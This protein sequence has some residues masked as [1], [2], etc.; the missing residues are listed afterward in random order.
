MVAFLPTPLLGEEPFN[1]ESTP[2]KLPK[3]VV[4]EEYAIRITPDVKKLTFTGSET[5]RVNVRKPTR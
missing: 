4:P 3:H 1:F 2:G 5:I